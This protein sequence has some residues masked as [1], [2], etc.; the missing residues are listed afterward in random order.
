VVED[1]GWWGV[2]ADMQPSEVSASSFLAKLRRSNTRWW[3]DGSDEIQWIFRGHAD[4]TWRLLPSAFRPKEAG[5]PLWALKE[6]LRLKDEPIEL[7][8]NVSPTNN[9]MSW[10]DCD[11]QRHLH[12]W[13][14]AERVAIEQFA[15]LSDRLSFSVPQPATYMMPWGKPFNTAIM[16]P[17]PI[18][19]DL[20]TA[21]VLAQPHGVPTRLLDWTTDPLVAA[22]HA[23]D[24]WKK[25]PFKSRDIAVWALKRGSWPV[26]IMRD[27]TASV[28]VELIQEIEPPYQGNAYLSAQRGVMTDLKTS[29]LQFAKTGAWPALEEVVRSDAELVHRLEK[30]ILQAD[31]VEELSNLLR[32]EGLSKARLMP[33]LDNVAKEIVGNW[34]V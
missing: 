34:P 6:H 13:L 22:F 15:T 18:R 7:N 9:D 12:A 5:N 24:E 25:R 27:P 3:T 1:G 29:N 14:K 32:R 19:G 28:E 10:I 4:A 20:L 23:V 26:G 2:M 30:F 33:S 21:I 8:A 17:Q 31:A 16:N 11:R